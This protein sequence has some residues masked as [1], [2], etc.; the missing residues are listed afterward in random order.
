[1]AAVSFSMAPGRVAGAP[2]PQPS[3][4][5]HD[6]F[7]R[8]AS[9][10]PDGSC[11]LAAGDDRSL[12]L[13]A[14]P[15]DLDSSSSSSLQPAWT[16]QPSDSLLS[17][18]WYPGASAANPNMFAFAVGVKD[19]PVHLLDGN[20]RRVRAS[21]PIVDHVERFV[22]P[23]SM[24]FSPDGSSL[25]CGFE[26]AI[27]IFDV[28]S[29][30]AAG[31]RLN[32]IPTR[33]SRDGQKGIISSLA[34]SSP[35][36]ASPGSHF[37]AA[38]SFS[39]TI[40]LY[41]P[42]SRTPLFDLLYPS[43]KGGVTK[44]LFNPLS[45]HLLFAASRQ[46]THL[47]VWDLRNTSSPTSHG[48]L[49]RPGRTNQRLGFSIDPT[50]TWLAAGDQDGNLN[51]FSALPLPDQLDPVAT[52]NLSSEPLGATVFHPSLPLL[53]TCS[54]T[55]HFQRYNGRS[56]GQRRKGSAESSLSASSESEEEE[57][58]EAGEGGGRAS[59]ELWRLS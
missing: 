58:E 50:G 54:G 13:F 28:A 51:V 19:H 12:S 7:F 48:R 14:L 27:E 59:L 57:R 25:C 9:I 31:F 2:A 33:S 23:T 37:L 39:G 17:T 40:G 18:A 42:S 47:D 35:D 36:P 34:F 22:A 10:C 15:S 52:F 16:H 53:L 4:K 55:R 32:T 21:Y 20:D 45:P 49:R 46:S 3:K 30:G 41:D 56:G 38:G 8:D 29:P 11:V 24:A 6:A 44:I 5:P 26:N 43:Q 1:M